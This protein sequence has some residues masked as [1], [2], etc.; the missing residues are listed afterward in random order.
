MVQGDGGQLHQEGVPGVALVRAQPGK[1]T[2]R[3]GSQGGQQ[4]WQRALMRCALRCVAPTDQ[5]LAQQV[6]RHLGQV[7]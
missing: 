3:I 2:H 6:E 5:G 7:V 1:V 4:F